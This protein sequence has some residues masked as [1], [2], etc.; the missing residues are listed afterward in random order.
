[1][2]LYHDIDLIMSCFLIR[3]F[4]RVTSPAQRN[5]MFEGMLF[6]WVWSCYCF[7]FFFFSVNNIQ[8]LEDFSHCPNLTELYIRKNKIKTLSEINHLRELP[9]LRN[10]WLADNPCSGGDNYRHTVLRTLPNLQKLDNVGK[11][12]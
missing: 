12:R 11:A 5:C 1:M 6:F 7:A 3:Y 8:T 9:K 10:L 2:T 4:L